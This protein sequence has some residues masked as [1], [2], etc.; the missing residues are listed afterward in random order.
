[1][2]SFQVH[3]FWA[4]HPWTFKE[5]VR[6]SNCSNWAKWT[7]SGHETHKKRLGKKDWRKKGKREETARPPILQGLSL[8]LAARRFDLARA[9]QHALCDF[10]NPNP[11]G[12]ANASEPRIMGPTAWC[13]QEKRA[14]YRLSRCI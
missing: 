4:I 3:G 11:L 1:M 6:N 2:P 7:K 13:G 14:D 9:F 8:M 5:A 12:M 10:L